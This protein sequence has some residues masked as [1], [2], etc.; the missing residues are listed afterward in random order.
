MEHYGSAGVSGDGGAELEG[1]EHRIVRG[2]IV[3]Y[4]ADD[5]LNELLR[6]AIGRE[7][8]SAEKVDAH[9]DGGSNHDGG[10]GFEDTAVCQDNVS[11]L[12]GEKKDS[13]DAQPRDKKEQDCGGKREIGR[14]KLCG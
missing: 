14:Q 13:E 6:G 10:N 2:G 7:A 12:N 4:I 5:I 3:S 1:G 11:G 9:N 8:H